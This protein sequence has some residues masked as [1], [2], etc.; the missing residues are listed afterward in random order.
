MKKPALSQP[1]T[2]V[3]PPAQAEEAVDMYFRRMSS[4]QLLTREG[5]VELAMR[6]ESGERAILGALLDS[7]IA[8][9][10]L[11]LVAEQL[12]KGR[13]KLREVARNVD[14]EEAF[15][16]ALIVL[17]ESLEKLARQ[18]GRTFPAPGEG[19]AWLLEAARSS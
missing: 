18:A 13:L 3:A 4:V 15:D 6:I 8:C 10:E 11:L 17:R 5:E 9:A 12:Y 7:P 1:P 16:D 2:S 14:D 19:V